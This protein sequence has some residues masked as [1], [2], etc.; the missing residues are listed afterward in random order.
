MLTYLLPENLEPSSLVQL[1]S[2]D[3]KLAV[4]FLILLIVLL[5]KPTGLFRGKSV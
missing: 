4:S 3:Y 5:F 2:T 1:L